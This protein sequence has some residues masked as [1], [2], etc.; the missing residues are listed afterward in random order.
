MRKIVFWVMVFVVILFS[1]SIVSAAAFL[2]D[3][4]GSS[5]VKSNI[6]VEKE[7]A[8]TLF[9]AGENISVNAAVKGDALVFGSVINFNQPVSRN[10]ISAGQNINLEKQIGGSVFAAAENIV[11]HEKVEGNVFVAAAAVK[12]SQDVGGDIFVGAGTL[13]I[14]ENVVIEGD[15]YARA[16]AVIKPDSVK[17]KGITNIKLDSPTGRQTIG[18]TAT[19]AFFGLLTWLVLGT[20]ALYTLPKTSQTISHNIT[21]KWS[22]SLLW[23]FLALIVTP[24]VIFLTFLSVIG[25]PLGFILAAFYILAIALA[26]I[27]IS[28]AIAKNILKLKTKPLVSLFIGL[29][30]LIL[31]KLIPVAGDVISLVVI[32]LG[33]G[34]I[35]LAAKET[36]TQLKDKI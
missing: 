35:L 6:S 3:G 18:Q 1:V 22:A 2:P 31:I 17:V 34:A 15:L 21:Q 29:I 7:V 4:T 23:G 14:A 10:V 24:I 26:P 32:L 27:F 16:G 28:L 9:S 25:W 5:Q 30:I 20:V 36:Y 8:N 11:I 13:E 12:I 33:L 19:A